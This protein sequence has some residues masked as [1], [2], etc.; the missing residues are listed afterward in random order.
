VAG[1]AGIRRLSIAAFIALVV[2]DVAILQGVGALAQSGLDGF[3]G[4]H[5]RTSADVVAGLLFPVGLSVAFVYGVV[6][7]LGWWR[8][9]LVDEH[10]VQPWV[11][12]VPAVFVGASVLAIDYGALADAGLGF[13]VLLL[14]GA[15]C[16]GFGEEGMFRGIGVT[17]F[18]LNGYGEARVALWSSVV[19]GAVHL[20]NAIGTGGAAI[21]QAIAVS[22][23]GYFFYLARRAAGGLVV[24]AV[25]HGVYDFS[26]LSGG[27]ASDHTYS[28]GIAAILAY[29]IVAV[30]VLVRRHRI[31]PA[32]AE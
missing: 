18:R 17:T 24:P 5:Y 2:V 13:T 21:G 29:P 22:F 12:V 9:V 19:F 28:G 31:E 27:V 3:E 6:A 30:I 4:G 15:L 1:P 26:I 32:A 23:A 10:P 25:V 8:P 16:V 14:L 7:W 20:S 11:W